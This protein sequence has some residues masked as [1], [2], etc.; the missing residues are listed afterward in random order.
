MPDHDHLFPNNTYPPL[1]M[2]LII[3]SQSGNPEIKPLL[4]NLYKIAL[5][6]YNYYR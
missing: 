5:A 6:A 1:F 3:D 2:M 4:Y